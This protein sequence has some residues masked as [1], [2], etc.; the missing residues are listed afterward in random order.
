MGLLRG[1]KCQSSGGDDFSAQEDT[2]GAMLRED[3]L[4]FFQTLRNGPER[5]DHVVAKPYVVKAY[6]RRLGRSV[7]TLG[8][9]REKC[10]GRERRGREGVERGMGRRSCGRWDVGR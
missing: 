5:A 4:W 8:E 2:E 10:A 3:E 7:K 9:H 6:L 1:G